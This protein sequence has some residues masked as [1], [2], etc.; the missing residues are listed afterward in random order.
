[1]R[2]AAVAKSLKSTEH[3]YLRVRKLVYVLLDGVGDRP[4]P[5][6]GMRTPLEAAVTPNLDSLTSRGSTGLVYTVGR[7][8]APESD[9]AVFHM[10]GYRLGE[11]YPGRGVIE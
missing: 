4:D 8:I 5:R 3:L 1:M 6:L 2:R 11:E 7:E 9:V 10:L